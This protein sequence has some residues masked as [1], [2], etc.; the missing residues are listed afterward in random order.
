MKIDPYG[1]FKR[2]YLREST[3]RCYPAANSVAKAL[4]EEEPLDPALP[5]AL[6]ALAYAVEVLRDENLKLREDLAYVSMRFD[7]IDQYLD[8]KGSWSSR[9]DLEIDWPIEDDINNS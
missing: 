4:R 5:N 2:S 8:P 3:A 1:Y 7:N 9:P 6:R